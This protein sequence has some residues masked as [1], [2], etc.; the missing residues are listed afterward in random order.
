MERFSRL[1]QAIQTG[2]GLMTIMVSYRINF[3]EIYYIGDCFL[4]TDKLTL[5]PLTT[6]DKFNFTINTDEDT[7]QSEDGYLA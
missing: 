5:C 6:I 3:D 7:P 1:I 4:A 2:M